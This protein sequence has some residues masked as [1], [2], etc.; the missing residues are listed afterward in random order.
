MAS[1]TDYLQVEYL[2]ALL[3]NSQ[4]FVGCSWEEVVAWHILPS[5]EECML[6]NLFMN[7]TQMP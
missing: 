3:I 5:T 4:G 1:R 6:G 7:F 2:P